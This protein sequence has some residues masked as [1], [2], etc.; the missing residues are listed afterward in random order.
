MLSDDEKKKLQKRYEEDKYIRQL[1][2]Y[3]IASN[4]GGFFVPIILFFAKLFPSTILKNKDIDGSLSKSIFDL[5]VS[6]ETLTNAKKAISLDRISVS[7]ATVEEYLQKK[8][9]KIKGMLKKTLLI[10]VFVFFSILI[11]NSFF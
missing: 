6:N 2:R 3:D 11:I 7:K 4:V 8:S 1:K 5:M 9:M 10:I